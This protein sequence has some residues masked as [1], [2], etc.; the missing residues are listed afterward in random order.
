MDCNSE[1]YNDKLVKSNKAMEEFLKN[2]CLDN[3]FVFK[4]G[5]GAIRSQR[6]TSKNENSKNEN[7]KSKNKKKKKKRKNK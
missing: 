3:D 7:S 4:K 5:E 6:K 1:D 2:E